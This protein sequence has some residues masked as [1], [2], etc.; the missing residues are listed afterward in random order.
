MRVLAV[1]GLSLRVFLH[2]LTEMLINSDTFFTFCRKRAESPKLHETGRK[3]EK[4]LTEVTKSDEIE[5][6][7]T[8]SV[9]LLPHETG[10]KVTESDRKGRNR[11]ESEKRE[12]PSPTLHR[13]STAGEV[14]AHHRCYCSSTAG[15]VSAQRCPSPCTAGTVS[16]QMDTTVHSRHRVCAEVHPTVHSRHLLCAE[17]HP[18]VHSRHLLCA[19]YPTLCTA[20]T[21]SAQSLFSLLSRHLSAQSLSPCSRKRHLVTFSQES[22]E[23]G[24]N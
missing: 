2:F 1:P 24:D 16:A 15:E 4:K 17:V 6:K 3:V 18:S 22:R 9:S 11:Q 10:R 5:Q 19:E 14:S 7:V 21:Y 23:E 13:S 20:G 12:K 8:K